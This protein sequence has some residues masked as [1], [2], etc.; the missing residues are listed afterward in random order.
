MVWQH[1]ANW[2]HL[3]SDTA[4]VEYFYVLLFH[5]SCTLDVQLHISYKQL[6]LLSLFRVE[7]MFW[8]APL[9]NSNLS[10]NP[11]ETL[12]FPV[13]P[14]RTRRCRRVGSARAAAAPTSRS[15]PRGA[16][17]CARTAARCSRT[18]S[19]SPR[20]SSRRARTAAAAPS[21]SSCRR[22]RKAERPAS[23]HVSADEELG[24]G[25]LLTGWFI[26]WKCMDA[27]PKLV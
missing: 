8:E 9:R 27:H 19:S 22:S 5:H 11:R 7:V 21:D 6:K 15:T 25:G 24:S 17:R 4:G 23:E 2:Q 10:L 18:T 13:E 16:T 14:P 12:A 3:P 1:C 20:C 26:C